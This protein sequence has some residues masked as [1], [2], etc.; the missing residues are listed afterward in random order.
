VCYEICVFEPHYAADRDTAYA[1]WNDEKYWATSLPEGERTAKKWR[2]KD[3]LLAFDNRLRWRE[4]EAPKTGF[5][6]KW[7]SKP[8]SIR[9]SLY[10]N[11]ED[12]R[13]EIAFDLF[14][15]AIEIALLWQAPHD[16]VKDQVR[17]VWKYLEQLSASGWSTIYDTERDV[18][19]N[20]QTDFDA[21][22]ARYLEN[23]V[24]DET[25]RVGAKASTAAA[26][27]AATDS[28]RPDKPFTGNVD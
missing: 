22:V 19:L 5:F 8:P 25:A 26:R 9:H 24:A 13:G 11:L 2:V 6:A 15:N 7:F 17:A 16:E 4:P 12:D 28:P 1:A 10:V 14:D 23:L 20:L 3:L 18:L 21:V 27:P